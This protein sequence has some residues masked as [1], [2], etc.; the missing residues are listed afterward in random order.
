MFK[1]TPSIKPSEVT[2]GWILI[3]ADGV[4]L[5]RLAAI[6]AQRLV[7]GKKKRRLAAMTQPQQERGPIATTRPEAQRDP[8]AVRHAE[9]FMDDFPECEPGAMPPFGNLYGMRVYVEPHLAEDDHIAFNAGSLEDSII[10]RVDDWLRAARPEVFV[11]AAP[12]DVR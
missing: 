9:D 11:F 8:A 3:D 12:G 10:L 7:P 2:K 6:I 1:S 5:G 4:V